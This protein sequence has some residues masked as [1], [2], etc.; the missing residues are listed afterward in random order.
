M[1]R[2]RINKRIASVL[3]AYLPGRISWAVFHI[4]RCNTQVICVSFTCYH[5]FIAYYVLVVYLIAYITSAYPRRY[6]V[7]CVVLRVY[8]SAYFDGVSRLCIKLV[9]SFVLRLVYW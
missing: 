3:P 6:H 2:H 9:F 4:I 5:A 8:Q 7:V 1:Q